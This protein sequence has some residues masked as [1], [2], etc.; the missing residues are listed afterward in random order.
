M[1]SQRAGVLVCI[2]QI[3]AM[4]GILLDCLYACGLVAVALCGAE[5]AY[6]TLQVDAKIR[7][8][9]QASQVKVLAKR[10][11]GTCL[12]DVVQQR[13]ADFLLPAPA[14]P[15][16]VFFQHLPR[17]QTAG[18]RLM[19]IAQEWRHSPFSQRR[20]LIQILLKFIIG[21]QEEICRYHV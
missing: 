3:A 13:L 14:C 9:R 6:T 17:R 2:T 16:M 18:C 5:L 19:C 21:H 1:T 20:R 8:A 10:L 11:D 7:L 4:G 15:V 12:I